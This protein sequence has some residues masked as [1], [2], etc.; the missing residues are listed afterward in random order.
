MITFLYQQWANGYQQLIQL[1]MPCS[2]IIRHQSLII[3]TYM[4]M[5]IEQYIK[6]ILNTKCDCSCKIVRTSLHIQSFKFYDLQNLLGMTNRCKTWNICRTTLAL[7]S[8]K[9]SDMD[10]IPSSFMDLLMSKIK[11]VNYVYTFPKSG[12]RY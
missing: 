5:S 7:S 10:K 12:H 4:C 3:N 9:V 11:Y 8:L 1:C 6:H 2:L